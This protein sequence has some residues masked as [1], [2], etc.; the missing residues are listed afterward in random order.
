MEHNI[1]IKPIGVVKKD[2]NG[3]IIK[4]NEEYLNAL[5]NLKGF[6][7]LQL[8]LWGHLC[9][10]NQNRT[11]LILEKIFKNGPDKM[12]VFATRS[13]VRPNPILISTIKIDEIDYKKGIIYT[14]SIDAED[15]TP[16]L[17]IKPYYLMKRVK[18]CKVPDWCQHWPQWYEDT[19][20]FNW[21][22]E[23]NL[24]GLN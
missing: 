10:T 24:S 23:I 7:H 11:T 14:P 4:I 6:S 2:D 9:D 18:D 19:T 8:V 13:P 17:D 1:K 12:G 22:K 21:K 5:T 3:F 20:V 15:K 16:V